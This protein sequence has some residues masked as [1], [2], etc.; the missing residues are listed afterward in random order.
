MKKTTIAILC[1]LGFAACKQ[2]P[3][4]KRPELPIPPGFRGDEGAESREAQ[5]SFGDKKWFEVI[6]DE[7]LQGLI[8]EA[9]Q[10]NYDVRLAAERVLEARAFVT[11]TRANQFP[12]VSGNAAYSARRLSENGPIAVPPGTS[13]EVAATEVTADLYWELDFWGKF[14]RATE[15]ARADL[16]A[17][18]E[19]RLLVIQ[20]LVTQVAIAHLELE[21]LDLELEISQRTLALRK[22]SL[23]LVSSRQGGGVDS[24][25]AVRQAESLVFSAAQLI[26]QL[27]GSIE[28]QENLICFLLG[29]N[30]GP[31]ARGKPL[32]EQDLVADLPAGLPSQ[33]IERRPDIALAEQQ[34]VAANARIGVAKAALFPTISLTAGAGVQSGQLSQLFDSSSTIWNITP[35]ISLPI[36]NSGQ[37]NAKVEASE[38]QQRAALIQYVQTVQ[39]AFKDVSD[40]LVGYRSTRAVR[41]EKDSLTKAWADAK[42]LS[43]IRYKGGVTSY[44]EVIDTERQYFEAELSL[45]QTER[46]VLV[47]VIRLYKSLGGGWQGAEPAGAEPAGS[48]PTDMAASAEAP[49]L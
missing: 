16:L 22:E 25:M 23:R 10:A 12:F 19:N 44:L 7:V 13:R 30:P 43:Q 20:S 1:V 9:L 40:A 15:A 46:D 29:R 6:R 45:A 32:L 4:Y 27:Q 48:E 14:A 37:L 33:L 36:F 26:P 39:F 49:P 35:A 17:T 24:L 11:V 31:V 34:L 28:Q 8:R 2:G 3:D 38:A 18:E 21:E 47:S 5:P 41:V 42:R